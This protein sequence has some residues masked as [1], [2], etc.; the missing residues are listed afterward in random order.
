MRKHTSELIESKEQVQL[1]LD[2]TGEAIY[3]ID[4]DGNCTFSNAACLRILGYK[5]AGPLI[6]RNMHDLIHHTKDDGTPYPIEE[7]CIYQAFR[8]G[9]GTHV[10]DEVLW[11]VDGTC[12][13][14]EYMSYPIRKDSKII[15]AVVTFSDITER[16]RKD[17]ELLLLKETLEQRVIERTESLRE[18]EER[19]RGLVENT[20]DWI[21]EINEHTQYIYASPQV[22]E[23]LGYEPDE[24]IGMTPFDLMTPENQQSVKKLFTEIAGRQKPFSR[25]E[26]SNLHKDGHTVILETSGVPIL[27]PDGSFKGYRGIDRDITERKKA[28]QALIQSEKLK[29]IGTITAGIS[30]EFNNL[31][32]II[33]G[34]VQL[35]EKTYKDHEE[36]MSALHTIKKASDDGAEITSKMLEFTKTSQDTKKFVSSDIRKLI[37]QSIDF[38]KPRWSNEAQVRSI[39]YQIDKEGLKSTSSI[40]CNPTEIREVFINIINNALD[41]MPEGGSLSFSIWNRENTVFAGISDTGEGMPEDVKKR[42]FDPFFTTKIPVGTGLGMSMTYG[43]ITRHGGKIEVES[44]LGRGSTFTLQFPTTNK[45]ASLMATPGPEQETDE[46]NLRILVVDDEV[47]ICT[48]LDKYLSRA[49]HKVKTVNNGSDAIGKIKAEDFDLIL[50]DLAMPDVFGYDV[51]KSARGL[52]KKPKIGIITGWGEKL[53]II[54]EEDMKVEFIVKKPFNLSELTNKINVLFGM[55]SR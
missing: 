11:R 48:I 26:N 45:R 32:A 15:G 22:R 18:S 54:N 38:T 24:V 9:K 16:K 20:N 3:G 23:L 37:M 28:E 17:E 33:S 30:H 50:C 34:N 7:C 12:F 49:G 39:N 5:D 27:G 52:G 14:A 42:V 10:D 29:S 46:K 31:L 1:L 44:E 4:S 40:M 8:E 2:S 47:D 21:W 6:G 13:P 55:D 35:L 53:K 25:L 51:I 41:A 19:F 36:L 43:I